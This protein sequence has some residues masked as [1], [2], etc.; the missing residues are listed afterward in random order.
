MMTWFSSRAIAAEASQMPLKTIA[1][2]VAAPAAPEPRPAR[3]ETSP[4][5]SL[6]I[7]SPASRTSRT[8]RTSS[9]VDWGGVASP[10]PQSA[11]S[12]A[13]GREPRR[14]ESGGER[15]AL[16]LGGVQA[17]EQGRHRGLD[18][19]LG[20]ARGDVLRAVP[21][22]TL[23]R[24]DDATL[25]DGGVAGVGE[26]RHQ[27]GLA[28]GVDLTRVAQHLQAAPVRVVHQEQ[29]YPVVALEV[30]EADI[31]PVAEEVGEAERAVV[32]H[33]EEAWRAAAVLDVGP[34]GLAHRGHVEA[35]TRGDEGGLSG[36]EAVAPRGL[37]P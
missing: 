10:V 20:E 28:R 36:S 22:E 1:A 19:G 34:A 29:R 37:G 18:L 33:L 26:L 30:A 25:D 15:V 24:D 3:R 13:G 14:L 4:I 6:R 31:L 17:L 21:V 16:R 32:K 27:I 23:E 35:V 8:A 7:V 12:L 11:R 2:G 5:A 9:Y